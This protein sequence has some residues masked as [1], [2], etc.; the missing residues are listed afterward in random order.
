MFKVALFVFKQNLI[1]ILAFEEILLSEQI[2]H[3]R[4]DAEYVG[5]ER[6]LAI[7]QNLRGQVPRRAQDIIGLNELRLNL[8]G[9]T[10]VSNSKVIIIHFAGAK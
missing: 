7:R 6:V 4:P 1:Q 9:E 10:E 5:F 8:D 2:I 3:N